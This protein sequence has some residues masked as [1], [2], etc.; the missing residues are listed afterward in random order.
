MSKVENFMKITTCDRQTAEKYLEA[1]NGDVESAL[2]S[3]QMRELVIHEY[4]T[5]SIAGSMSTNN[6]ASSPVSIQDGSRISGITQAINRAVKECRYLLIDVYNPNLPSSHTFSQKV[7]SNT[8]V[9]N[10][11]LLNFV[12]AQVITTSEEGLAYQNAFPNANNSEPPTTH[13]A[14]LNPFTRQRTFYWNDLREPE[15]VFRVLSAIMPDLPP[16]RSV[17]SPIATNPLPINQNTTTSSNTSIPQRQVK[18]ASGNVP[19]S[20][21]THRPTTTKRP[22]IHD[23]ADDKEETICH[24]SKRRAVNINERL[25]HLSIAASPTSDPSSLSGPIL[26]EL[27]PFQNVDDTFRVALRFPS[28]ERTILHLVPN[29]TLESLFSYFEHHGFPASGYDLV[30]FY[31]NFR[32][33][34]LPRTAHIDE[35]GLEKWD[36]LY[37]QCKF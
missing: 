8:K 22:L 1:N 37:L 33:N 20:S 5:S 36:T 11:M 24:S 32:L 25:S 28:G 15:E 35:I 27:P 21:M 10:L 29:L 31:P 18:P 9:V 19:M 26:T 2:R 17:S 14:L 34:D 4:M 30:H 23:D 7:W 12:F 16:L 3:Y 6:N 13:F